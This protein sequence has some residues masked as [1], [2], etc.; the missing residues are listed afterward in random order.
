MNK[1]NKETVG[2]HLRNEAAFGRTFPVVFVCH[3]NRLHKFVGKDV[4]GLA[5]GAFFMSIAKVKTYQEAGNAA[6]CFIAE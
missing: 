2:E 5:S 6:I 3:Q 4:K 1:Q